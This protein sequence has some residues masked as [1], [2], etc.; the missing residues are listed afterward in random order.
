MPDNLP[1]IPV[2]AG[3]WID[4]Y[5]LSGITVGQ[6]LIVENVGVADLFLAVQ[7]A[8]PPTDHRS[9]NILK[10]DD[11]IRLT[12]T[13]GDLGAWVFCNG[14]GGLISVAEL[15]G[16]QPLLNSA[17]HDGDGNPIGSYKGALDVHQAEVHSEV[18]NELFNL[19]TGVETT[20]A[21]A[22]TA[23]DTSVEVA[24]TTGFSVGSALEIHDGNRE[25]TFPLITALPGANVMALDRPLD[26]DYAIGDT[27][28]EVHTDLRTSLGTLAAPV[29]HV[30][31]PGPGQVWYINRI[32]IAMVHGSAGA[33]DLFGDLAALT[34]GVVLRANINGQ[35]GSFTNWKSNGDIRLD[36]YDVAYSDKA[37]GPAGFGTSG[38]GSFSRIG[39]LVRLDGDVG[40]FMDLLIQDDVTNLASFFING[41]G[42]IERT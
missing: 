41:Q 9:Y 30:I 26:F 22:V 20:I 17:L 36:M 37:G 7:A 25:T 21:V 32:I 11:D 23:G 4:L 14:A 42:Y 12:N 18:V 27:V 33:D 39:V 28:D 35:Y 13:L 40:D 15:E 5:A 34:N 6:P 16:F 1:L 29:V 3:S 2:E 24:D 19:H 31:K 38:R 10:R 8:Q